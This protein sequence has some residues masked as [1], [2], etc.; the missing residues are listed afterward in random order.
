MNKSFKTYY[1]NLHSDNSVSG[2]CSTI[3]EKFLPEILQK[4]IL[5]NTKFSSRFMLYD[6]SVPRYLQDKPT[7]FVKHCFQR[8]H[9][10]KSYNNIHEDVAVLSDDNTYNVVSQTNKAKKHV[11]HFGG[12]N[13]FP[14]C[15]CF[16][17]KKK[18]IPC[19]HFLL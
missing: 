16:D 13:L 14:T 1:N 15:D 7:W 12:I 18:L 3:I 4:Y 11:V 17:Y 19:K 8:L 6:Y 5:L 9:S 2:L 10:A